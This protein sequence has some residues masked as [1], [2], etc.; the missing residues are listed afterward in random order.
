M[1]RSTHYVG[2][3]CPEGHRGQA[4]AATEGPCPACIAGIVPSR[5]EDFADHLIQRIESHHGYEA[6]LLASNLALRAALEE[7]MDHF[8]PEGIDV[9]DVAG[10]ARALLATEGK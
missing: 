6:D 10:R 4:P 3:G 1:G 8:D 9:C 2:D 7:Y 5:S